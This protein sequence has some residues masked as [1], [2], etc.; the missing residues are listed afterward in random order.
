MVVLGEGFIF[1]D[2]SLWVFVSEDGGFGVF[3]DQ[4]TGLGCEREE[5]EKRM[6]TLEKS[7]SV[8]ERFY[9]CQREKD[10][11]RRSAPR[12]NSWYIVPI[13]FPGDSTGADRAGVHRAR[14]GMY[15]TTDKKEHKDKNQ[16]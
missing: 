6:G 3:M 10:Q 1:E 13:C 4:G 5:V 11:S 12:E 9:E 7:K 2:M 15:V 8:L 14:V 16:Q